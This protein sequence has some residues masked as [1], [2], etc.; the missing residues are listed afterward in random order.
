MENFNLIQKRTDNIM[1]SQISI[2]QI[3]QL[4]ILF[5]L[6]AVPHPHFLRDV[7]L[8]LRERAR[9][10]GRERVKETPAKRSVRR[11]MDSSALGHNLSQNEEYGP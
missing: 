9:S 6:N 5:L 8:Y 11:R 1:N 2:P 4:P 10:K 3:K 7:F